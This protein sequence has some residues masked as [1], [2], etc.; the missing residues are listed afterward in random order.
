MPKFMLHTKH[1]DEQCLQALREFFKISP[2][3]LNET[4]YGCLGGEHSGWV[5]VEAKDE[6][7]AR[8]KLPNLK[9][10]EMSVVKVDKFTPGQLKLVHEL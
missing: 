6:K 8:S 9:F 10:S 1:T 3:L 2:Q 4:H 7:E 5:V